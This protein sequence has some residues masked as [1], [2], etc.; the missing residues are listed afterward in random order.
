MIR[1]PSW[2]TAGAESFANGPRTRGAVRASARSTTPNGIP[3][4]ILAILGT[5]S[6]MRQHSR[7][8]PPWKRAI[9]RRGYSFWTFTD[10]FEENY[11]P[12]RPFHGGFG[13]LNLHGIAKPVY[14]AFELLHGLGHERLLVD[15]MHDT[16]NAWVTR[17]NDVVKILLVNHALPRHP[18]TRVRTRVHLTRSPKPAGAWVERIDEHHANAKRRWQ[19]LGAPEYLDERAVDQ[20]DRAS[21]VERRA[22]RWTWRE[23]EVVL[24][25]DL[26]PHSVAALTLKVGSR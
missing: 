26:P 5:T 16:V 6:L 25:V 23:R 10:I 13:L 3:R 24:A 7:Q 20:L 9:S 1:I 2:P 12:S 17:A 18:I 8:R 21:R 14:R 4:P 22:C 19:R 15:G 11:L